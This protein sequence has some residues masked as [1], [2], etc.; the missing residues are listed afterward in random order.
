[1][2]KQ[3]QFSPQSVEKQIAMIYL[4]T[5]NL[6][7]TIPVNRVREFEVAYV[8][9]LENK[10]KDVLDSLKAGKIDDNVTKVLESVGAE[11]AK[12]YSA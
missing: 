8:E 3:A 6:L 5:K 12:N 10:H 9:Y 11:L 4:G 2:L 7:R 1:M